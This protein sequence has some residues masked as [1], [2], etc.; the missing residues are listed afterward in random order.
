MKL[1]VLVDNNTFI[2]RYYFGEPA[3]SYYI[4]DREHKILFDVGY[5][6][7]FLWNAEVMQIDL[8]QVD[9]LVLSHGHNDHTGGL[10]HFFKEKKDINVVTHPLSL[11]YKEE[12]GEDIGSPLLKEDLENLC[13]LYLSKE[14]VEISENITY[15]G[16]IPL[17]HAFEKRETIGKIKQEEIMVEDEVLEDSAIVYKG[18]K[19]LFIITGCSHAGI[20]NIISYAKKVC[21]EDRI[22][23]V[24][25]GFHLFEVNERLEKTIVFLKEQHIPYLYPCHC[26]SLEAKV[27]IAKQMKIQEVGVGLDIQI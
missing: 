25:G 27:E 7:V 2:D 6:E 4:E 18:E 13:H 26:I 3:V 14:P 24:I 22:Y 1:K 10:I 5:S 19:G 8:N 17:V 12:E 11:V 15:L 16:E 21:Q 20:C 9:T 23:G